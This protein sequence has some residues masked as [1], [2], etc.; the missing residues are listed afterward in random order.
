M[1]AEANFDPTEPREPGS[2]P[3][4]ITKSFGSVWRKYSDEQPSSAQT[5]IEG[6]VVRCVLTDAVAGF[7]RGM[8]LARTEGSPTAERQ[9]DEGTY[10]R[11]A[12]AAVART[13]RRRVVALISNRDDRTGVA[14]EVFILELERRRQT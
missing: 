2:L 9:L 3:S 10:R 12:M 14:R 8:A 13:T 1:T 7:N 6:N 5:E 4:E 11:D